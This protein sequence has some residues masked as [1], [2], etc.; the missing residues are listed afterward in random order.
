M[1]ACYQPFRDLASAVVAIAIAGAA[2]LLAGAGI[3]TPALASDYLNICR[4]ADGVYEID[5]GILR[6]TDGNAEH[7]PIPFTTIEDRLLSREAGYCI[8]NRAGGS[9]FDYETKTSTL[10]AAFSDGGEGMQVNFICEF[11][12][13]GLPAAY[14]CD[15]RV[16]VSQQKGSGNASSFGAAG[17][18]RWLHNGSLMRL[19]ASGPRRRFFYVAP[20]EGMRRA[21][22]IP[23]TLLFDGARDAG[24]YS[25]TAY[26]FAAGCAP[27]P[28]KVD[29]FVSGGDRRIV[30]FGQAP[31]VGAR[32]EVTG[33]RDDTLVF[34]FEPPAGEK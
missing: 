33:Y 23:G 30:M 13:D 10:R 27:E 16:I 7:P 34:T 15:Q 31:R 5:D 6:R 25:G 8:A 3:A 29:G 2:T 18:S 26:I 22:V 17:G 11:A 4:S 24:R 32:C 20:R 28:Y 21:G 14:D 1:P 19:E 12:A 9:R